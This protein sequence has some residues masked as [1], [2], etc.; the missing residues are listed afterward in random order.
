MCISVAELLPSV[1]MALAL[2]PQHHR[3]YFFKIKKRQSCRRSLVC[4]VLA[5]HVQ[6]LCVIHALGRCQL[7]TPQLHSEFEASLGF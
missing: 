4:R 6:G 3:F 1:R 7:E 2:I 5:C